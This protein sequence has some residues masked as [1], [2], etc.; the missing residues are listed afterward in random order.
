MMENNGMWL[1]TIDHDWDIGKNNALNGMLL[2]QYYT[3]NNK[4]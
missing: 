2:K 4:S 1:G 3:E